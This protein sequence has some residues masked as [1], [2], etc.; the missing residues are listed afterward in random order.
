M[1]TIDHARLETVNGG[2]AITRAGPFDEMLRDAYNHGV[3][4]LIP[5]LPEMPKPPEWKPAFLGA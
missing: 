2:V 4:R 3:R 5:S 1:K